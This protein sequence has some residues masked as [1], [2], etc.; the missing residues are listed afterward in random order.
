MIVE[1]S[2]WAES[3]GFL[4]LSGLEVDCRQL[5]LGT[6]Y[7]RT[8]EKGFAGERGVY[9]LY[10]VPSSSHH[11]ALAQRNPSGGAAVALISVAERF[12][13][14]RSFSFRFIIQS[15]FQT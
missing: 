9:I 4:A 3:F 6:I 10:G 5:P 8:P 15:R 2:L 11:V 12:S 13:N 1:W 7:H 14:A